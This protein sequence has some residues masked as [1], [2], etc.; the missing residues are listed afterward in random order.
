MWLSSFRVGRQPRDVPLARTDASLLKSTAFTLPACPLNRL[1][2]DPDVTSHRKTALSPP[3]DANRE[4]SGVL[5]DDNSTET[6]AI[7]KRAV[8]SG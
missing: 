7:V 3:D 6:S 1:M 8:R 5:I 2:T 4:L